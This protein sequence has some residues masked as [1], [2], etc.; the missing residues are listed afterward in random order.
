[1]GENFALKG[2]TL[3]AALE[4][5]GATVE[6]ESQGP[7][8]KVLDMRCGY[9]ESVL[10]MRGEN[11]I[12]S[13]AFVAKAARDLGLPVT[14]IYDAVRKLAPSELPGQSAGESPA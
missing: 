14:A 5:L 10:V 13:P 2:S 11:E 9:G 8:G 4:E 7:L 1:M 6:Q 12:H 3:L